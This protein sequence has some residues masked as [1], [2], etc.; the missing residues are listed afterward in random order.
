MKGENPH[1]TQ[2]QN[3][4]RNLSLMA[5]LKETTDCHNVTNNVSPD[6]F[7]DM[8]DAKSPGCCLK[9]G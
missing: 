4:I 2:V 1:K 9:I 5:L 8:I 3:F 6:Y 7:K